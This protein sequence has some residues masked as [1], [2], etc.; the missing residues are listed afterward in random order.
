MCACMAGSTKVSICTRKK[1]KQLIQKCHL[2]ENKCQRKICCPPFLIPATL[3]RD[4]NQ[5]LII[6]P[7]CLPV[8]KST[9]RFHVIPGCT[10]KVRSLSLYT[11]R[12]VGRRHAADR[13]RI[14]YA[15]AATEGRDKIRRGRLHPPRSSLLQFPPSPCEG[16]E[17]RWE[18]IQQ[19]CPWPWR[20][21]GNAILSAA[22][23]RRRGLPR[24]PRWGCRSRTHGRRTSSA[25]RRGSDGAG[26]C[27][28]EA[29]RCGACGASRT[30]TSTSS[31]GASIWGSASSR[32]PPAPG[33][34]A[35]CAA[36]PGG[37]A[38]WR[39]CPRST[40]TTP[41]TADRAVRRD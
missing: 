38:F 29:R 18:G 33:P 2:I 27:A 30:T 5:C 20:R 25:T 21:R 28:A 6:T 17:G 3:P 34:G 13:A 11:A 1:L 14:R 40:S 37:T 24:R 22:A 16:E 4:R 41:S 32:P 31:A 39:R 10:R 8:Q 12:Y 19:Q 7:C 9:V 23:R 35:R 36:A 15:N 26:A